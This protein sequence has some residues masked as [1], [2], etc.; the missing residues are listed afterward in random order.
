MKLR[1][2]ADADVDPDIRR[3]LLRREPSIDFRSAEG[4]I[5]DGTPHPEVL[6]IA[7]GDN[8]VLVT[9]R[10]NHE[11]TFSRFHRHS[12]FARHTPDSIV[13]VDRRCN[14]RTVWRVA[15]MDGR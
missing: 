9:R 13:T 7:A 11:R 14:R 2:Q 3:G 6:Q 10:A 12:R 4:I 5:R 15:G 1:F 8:R